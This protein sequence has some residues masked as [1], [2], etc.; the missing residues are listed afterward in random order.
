[1]DLTSIKNKVRAFQKDGQIS[2]YINVRAKKVTYTREIDKNGEMK[3]IK[4]ISVKNNYE[5]HH[6]LNVRGA[7]YGC[8]FSSYNPQMD[9]TLALNSG[10]VEMV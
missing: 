8:R 6:E 1:M 7:L 4:R 3:K 2:V 9:F 10:W 5:I